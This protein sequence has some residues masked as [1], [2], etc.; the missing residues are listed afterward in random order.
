MELQTIEG[1][2]GNVGPTGSIL[3]DDTAARADAVEFRHEVFRDLE[4]RGLLAAVRAFAEKM[5]VVRR[6]LA[7]AEKLSCAPERQRWFLDAAREYRAATV[8]PG[9]ALSEAPISSLGLLGLRDYVTAYLSGHAF[10]SLGV[11][12]ERVL[13]RLAFRAMSSGR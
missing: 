3:F 7:L 11:D 8:A 2:S 5:E 4:D 9:G 12:A 1:E 6:H 13:K 10:T